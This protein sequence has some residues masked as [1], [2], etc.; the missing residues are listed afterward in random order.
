MISLPRIPG[1]PDPLRRIRVPDDLA[2]ITS[3]GPEDDP[4]PLGADGVER[5]WKSAVGVYRSG[6][7]P[8]LQICVRHR[9]AVVLNRAIDR[10]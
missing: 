7:H 9:G 8:A 3:Q 6:V 10:R 1:L 5:I 4:G 2:S